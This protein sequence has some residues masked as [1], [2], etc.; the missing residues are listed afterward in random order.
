MFSIGSTSNVGR[1][2]ARI[3]SDKENLNGLIIRLLEDEDQ[4]DEEQKVNPKANLVETIKLGRE[5][6]FEIIPDTERERSIVYLVGPSGSGKSY[7]AKQFL[8]NYNKIFPRNPIFM[9]SKLQD[10]K[11]LEELKGKIKRVAIDERLVTEPLDMQDFG[12]DCV[13]VFDDTDTIRDKPI[14]EA[15]NKIRNAVLETGRH[16]NQTCLITS[17]LATKGNE[18]KTMLSEAHQIIMYPSSGMPVDYLLQNYVGFTTNMIRKVKQ[19][20]SRWIDVFRRYPQVI[21]SQRELMFVKDL[22]NWIP[23]SA[24]TSFEQKQ[25]NYKESQEVQKKQDELAILNGGKL[26]SIAPKWTCEVCHLSVSKSN[27]NKHEKSVKHRDNI[28]KNE[29]KEKKKMD[30]L[31]RKKLKEAEELKI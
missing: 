31:K 10:D 11:S 23:D 3:K 18:T 17:H 19:M 1:P 30:R 7:L 8:V 27:K 9:F 5:S 12:R 14:L 15:V 13:I 4:V 20:K 2:V 29:L 24:P 28:I 6:T 22:E 16:T 26:S 21:M 25:Q